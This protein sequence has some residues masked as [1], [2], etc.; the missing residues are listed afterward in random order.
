MPPQAVLREFISDL[1][2]YIVRQDV[3]TT[4]DIPKFDSAQFDSAH[5]AWLHA[6]TT[7]DGIVHAAEAQL[8]QLRRQVA[9]WHRPIAVA[10]NSPYRLCLR[11]QEPP[12]SAPDDIDGLDGIDGL[13]DV[14][15]LDGI[16]GL[17]DVDGLDEPN[18]PTRRDWYLRYLLQP[19]DDH[20]LLLPVDAAAQRRSQDADL[21]EF[22]LVSLAQAGVMC[23]P[24]ADSL[25]RRNP[26]GARLDAEQAHRFLTQT[27]IAAQNPA[28]STYSHHPVQ[29]NPPRH[30]EADSH[31]VQASGLYWIQPP[32]RISHRPGHGK[33][34]VWYHHHSEQVNTFVIR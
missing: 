32:H 9:E 19:H 3:D 33:H 12:Q 27:E 23:P 10:A 7:S 31:P 17:D 11:L 26:A 25:N 1:V 22:L 5:D 21:A 15:G 13:D 6:L 30:L 8:Q 18:P 24:V 2:N 34:V 20:S 14:D 16:D 29:H 4:G 28:K